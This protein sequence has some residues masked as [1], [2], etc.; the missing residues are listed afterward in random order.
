MKHQKIAGIYADS[1]AFGG[2][3]LTVCGLLHSAIIFLSGCKGTIIFRINK[4]ITSF[5]YFFGNFD[6]FLRKLFGN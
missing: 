2:R 1:A 5:F 3:E 4:I 6:A